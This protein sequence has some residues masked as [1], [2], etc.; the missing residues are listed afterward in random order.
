MHATAGFGQVP[1]EVTA[2]FDDEDELNDVVEELQLVGFQHADISVSP[3]WKSVATK[4]GRQ[5]ETVTEL[6]DA[7]GAPHAVPFDRGSFGL[8]QGACIAGPLYFFALG[9]II[10]FA[11][12]GA[13]FSAITIAAVV[14]GA[15]GAATGIL[16]VIWMRRRHRL[17]V[18]ELLGRGGLVLWL[19][20]LDD[21]YEQ[22]ARKILSRYAAR[23]L[24]RCPVAA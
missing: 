2:L 13:D 18:S 7:P 6:A 14:A 9:A 24:H 11:A 16:P 23:D 1:F 10:A 22:R 5:L 12:G 8:A 20:V 21:R 4:I 17:Y 3:T 15:I 19:R